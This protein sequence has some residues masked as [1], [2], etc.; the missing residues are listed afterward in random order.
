MLYHK[1]AVVMLT[2]YLLCGWESA[3]NFKGGFFPHLIVKQCCKLGM[4]ILIC[5][6]INLKYEQ[7]LHTRTEGVELKIRHSC[8]RA[9][10][11]GDSV[12]PSPTPT[13]P[14]VKHTA[15]H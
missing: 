1:D 9:G 15:D 4:V 10:V 12:A 14:V 6:N 8:S 11:C 3:R 2:E 7:G 13:P 5:R